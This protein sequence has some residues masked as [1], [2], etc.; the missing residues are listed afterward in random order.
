MLRYRPIR[1]I[2]APIIQLLSPEV[3]LEPEQE[4]TN[5]IFAFDLTILIY[6]SINNDRRA[7]EHP[8]I[9]MA[10]G[11]TEPPAKK[12]AEFI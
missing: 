2:N 12:N 1:T 11:T 9:L 6:K 10:G 5:N 8:I 3:I 7:E 4:T